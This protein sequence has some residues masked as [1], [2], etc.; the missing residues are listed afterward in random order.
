MDEMQGFLHPSYR[1]LKCLDDLLGPEGTHQMRT[2]L[3]NR[4]IDLARRQ[5]PADNGS[6]IHGVIHGECREPTSRLHT[7]CNWLS[8]YGI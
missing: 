8:W 7:L 1:N 6:A 2:F 5:I 3:K 4:V